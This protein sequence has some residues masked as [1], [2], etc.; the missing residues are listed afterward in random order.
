M[1]YLMLICKVVL[2]C[3]YDLIQ[4]N[5]KEHFKSKHEFRMRFHSTTHHHYPSSQKQK[6]FKMRLGKFM[7]LESPLTN[8][9]LKIWIKFYMMFGL[10]NIQNINFIIIYIGFFV[11]GIMLTFLTS[12]YI[13]RVVHRLDQIESRVE[14]PLNLLKSSD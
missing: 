11:L 9:R 6:K 10:I 2:I 8:K 13:F 1:M 4:M 3:K 7:S 14:L 5:K 12:N